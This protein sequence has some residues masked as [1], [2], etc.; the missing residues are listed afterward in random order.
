MN[1]FVG[2]RSNTSCGAS[3]G[4]RIDGHRSQCVGRDTRRVFKRIEAD[5]CAIEGG[6]ERLGAR[7]QAQLPLFG[8]GPRSEPHLPSPSSTSPVTPFIGL[9]QKHGA[10]F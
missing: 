10:R 4:T 1:D 7:E 2:S 3:R 8:V 5:E 9:H 6:R